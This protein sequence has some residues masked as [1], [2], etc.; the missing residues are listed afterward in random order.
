MKTDK[1]FKG[2]NLKSLDL[3][4]EDEHISISLNAANT[5]TTKD[6]SFFFFSGR[7]C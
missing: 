1:S 3:T 2:L 4:S 5:E 6:E 7:R